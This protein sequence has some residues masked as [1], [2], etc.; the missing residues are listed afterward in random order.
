VSN[1]EIK[2]EF[3]LAAR[4]KCGLAGGF[5]DIKDSSKDPNLNYVENP[6]IKT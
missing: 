6:A 4:T 3:K 2:K 5:V 1:E